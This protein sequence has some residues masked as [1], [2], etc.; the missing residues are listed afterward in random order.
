MEADLAKVITLK[1]FV[2]LGEHIGID[3]SI[4][5]GHIKKALGIT[6]KEKLNSSCQQ[7]LGVS[8]QRLIFHLKMI[9]AYYYSHVENMDEQEIAKKLGYSDPSSLC[10]AFKN[11]TGGQTLKTCQMKHLNMQLQFRLKSLLDSSTKT[12]EFLSIE[13]KNFRN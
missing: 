3:K 12:K 9:K 4:R 7:C 8:S 1:A 5:T 10:H 2:Y 6:D 11:Y 13:F